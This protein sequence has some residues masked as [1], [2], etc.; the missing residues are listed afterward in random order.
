MTRLNGC[1][2]IILLFFSTANTNKVFGQSE[3]TAI[4]DC[5]ERAMN[6]EDKALV[7]LENC[8]EKA[9]KDLDSNHLLVALT[10][11]K[12]GV[13][14]Y[15]YRETKE[16]YNKAIQYWQDALEI[17]ENNSESELKD[18]AQGYHNLSAAY[19]QLENY[20][21]AIKMQRKSLK[22]YLK[23]PD[24]TKYVETLKQLGILSQL[25][26]DYIAAIEFFTTGIENLDLFIPEQIKLK[27]ILLMEI[28]I[29]NG[30]METDESIDH[31]IHYY[32]KAL[33]VFQIK[34]FENAENIAH[35]YLNLGNVYESKKNYSKAKIYFQRANEFYRNKE[36][37]LP[38]WIKNLNNLG[39]VL[40]QN[41][42]LILAE[43]NL[44]LA[45]KYAKK[46][47]SQSVKASI[48][49]NLGEVELKRRKPHQALTFF[50][51]AVLGRINGY[52]EDSPYAKLLLSNPVI[53]VSSKPRLLKTLQR[54]ATALKA[55]NTEVSLKSALATYQTADTLLSLMK[56]DLDN[57]SSQ[58]FW[59]TNGYP[60]FN[61]AIEVAYELFEKTKDKKYKEIMFSFSEKNKA[62]V[63]LDAIKD[64]EAQMTIL[65]KD[66][67][68]KEKRIRSKIGV[69]E[70]QAAAI[71]QENNTHKEE[72]D[73]LLVYKEEYRQY[74]AFLEQKYPAYF[75]LKYDQSVNSTEKIKNWLTPNK[76]ILEYFIGTDNIYAFLITNEKFEVIPITKSLNFKEKVDS[77]Q[78][79]L[80]EK[81]YTVYKKEAFELYEKILA[82][83]LANLDSEKK[84]ELIVI[85]DGSLNY[86]P[87]EALLTQ[88][89]EEPTPNYSGLPYLINHYQFTYAYSINLLLEVESY[90]KDEEVSIAIFAPKFNEDFNL[91]QLNFNAAK[92]ILKII[93][94]TPYIGE[95][96]TK[97]NLLSI[98]GNQTILHVSSHA[99]MND[100]EP[101][102]SKIY[103]ADD[104]ITTAEIYNLPYSSPLAVLSACETGTG[105]Y[106]KGE[107]IISLARAFM[108]SGCPSVLTSLWKVDDKQTDELMDYF[109]TN[110]KKGQ[111]KA[112]ALHN[113]KIIYLDIEKGKPKNGEQYGP[114]YWA[115]FIHI[116]QTAPLYQPSSFY[117]WMILIGIG[118]L[119]L[120]F[121]RKRKKYKKK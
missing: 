14:Y 56:F 13:F 79:A 25:Q 39:N 53:S 59:R 24:K 99:L 50:H 92:S 19:E 95:K 29:T 111:N 9:Y 43:E 57:Q 103:L 119:I 117:K 110:L 106:Q 66:I 3:E 44:L 70:R 71:R 113:A 55:I 10:L 90:K 116:G 41:G 105:L 54:K 68:E 63:L 72:L 87:F 60:I 27:G 28:G 61:N 18:I 78:S 109:Y 38:E 73:S 118:L 82:P 23:N 16:G 75:R 107:G 12:F 4:K 101:L 35:C 98:K 83:A 22:I 64:V 36:Y 21:E 114:F 31:S 102:K 37:Y 42:E 91:G 30:K 52:K 69:F 121:F 85:P 62:T 89:V 100:K 112:Q 74:I 15:N 49:E 17:R 65:P 93:N 115:A 48:L 45:L 76:A 2:F 20:E 34:L 67:L 46:Q 77:L 120:L 26:G 108:Y 58:L 1:F 40:T 97:K 33:E 86:I 94:G 88:Y 81:N 96:A 8:L 5:I 104:S 11:H 47:E 7:K 51:E 6:F 80:S 84:Y 32:S